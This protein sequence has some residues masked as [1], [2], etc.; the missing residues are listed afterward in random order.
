[1]EY[2]NQLVYFSSEMTRNAH[3]KN[4]NE[5]DRPIIFC[6]WSLAKLFKI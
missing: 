6:K 3:K 2:K 5:D 1:M 4:Q